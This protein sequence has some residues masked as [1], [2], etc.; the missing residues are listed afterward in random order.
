MGRDKPLLPF[1]GKTLVEHIA[2]EVREAAGSVTLIG[3]PERLGS[4][5]LPA[6][7]DLVPD[8]GPLGGIV[9]AL[10]FSTAEWNLVVACDMP[11]VSAGFLRSL[12]DE[13]EQAGCECLAPVSPSGRIE[14]LCAVYRRTCLPG[15][16]RALDAGTRKMT[17]VL[18]QL[19]VLNRSVS[20]ADF[21]R[22]LN[23][24]EEWVT[25]E[26]SSGSESQG[27]HG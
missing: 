17:D 26:H 5:E 4:L 8:S 24:P 13:A 10:D 9:T 25:H 2:A 15:L 3:R 14:P 6:I 11:S 22:N 21:F 23:T 12:L 7:A 1:R 19:N 16:Q 20:E 18:A 27:V